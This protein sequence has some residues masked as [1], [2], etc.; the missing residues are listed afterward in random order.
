MAVENEIAAKV[1]SLGLGTV[2]ST[3]FI[4]GLDETPDA[5]CAVYTNPGGACEGGFGTTAVQRE[6]VSV[7]LW[8]RGA[9]D[10]YAG[11]QAQAE[12]AKAGFAAVQATTLSA[13]AGGTNAFYETVLAYPPYRLKVDDHGRNIFVTRLQITKGPSA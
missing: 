12:L 8:F 9:P 3:I 10:D 1:A 7:A 11:P 2:A 13:G 4:G 5:C 6:L